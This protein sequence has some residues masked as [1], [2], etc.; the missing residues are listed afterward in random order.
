V[1]KRL[2]VWSVT[3]YLAAHVTSREERDFGCLADF[4]SARLE[5][6]AELPERAGVEPAG[7]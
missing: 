3:A 6:H 2:R 5:R 7:P 4:E 1:R